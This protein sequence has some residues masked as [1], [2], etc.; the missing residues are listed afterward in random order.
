MRT[1]HP[2]RGPAE[3]AALLRCI[4]QGVGDCTVEYSRVQYSTVLEQ[5]CSARERT[6]A[7]NHD[8]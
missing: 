4:L 3:A 5:R 1:M 6:Q 7:A 8:H 2:A